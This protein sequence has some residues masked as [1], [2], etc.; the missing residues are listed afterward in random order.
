MK[1]ET[2]F[3]L[4]HNLS[5]MNLKEEIW[6]WSSNYITTEKIYYE[7]FTNIKFTYK[8]FFTVQ[9]SKNIHRLIAGHKNQN[10]KVILKLK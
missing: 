2:P 7:L 10:F 9:Q 8:I 1:G 4:I 6:T 3:N 5:N